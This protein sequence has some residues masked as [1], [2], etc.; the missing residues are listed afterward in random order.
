MANTFNLD[1]IDKEKVFITPSVSDKDYVY[2]LLYSS[3]YND[4]QKAV[5]DD[6]LSDS[7]LEFD[8]FNEIVHN[9]KM[10]QSDSPN[11]SMKEI[12]KQIDLKMSLD[13]D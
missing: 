6:E 4:E 11:P 8:R 3:N 7:G 10:N 9:L 5:I 12:Q 2:S 13:K 1:D